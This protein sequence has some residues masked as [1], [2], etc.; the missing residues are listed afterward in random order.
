[1]AASCVE[2]GFVEEVDNTVRLSSPF[3]PS[4]IGGKPAWLAR[5]NL[6]DSKLLLC[7][8]CEKP[9][10]FLLQVYVPSDNEDSTFHRTI[11]VFCCRDG[12]CYKANSNKCFA[13]FR[14]QLPRANEFYDPDVT[15]DQDK[16]YCKFLERECK[17]NNKW[18]PLCEICGCAGNKQ[19][20]KCHLARYCSK[21]HQT[22]DWK[23]GHK[24][25]CK[26]AMNENTKGTLRD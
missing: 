11:F 2:L 15:E 5:S 24:L 26:M 1:M 17:M 25:A 8:C 21:N 4:K 12:A 19:C 10:I 23:R 3:F 6:P 16:H 18:S 13:A 9:L 7:Q 20:G 14:C 22:I